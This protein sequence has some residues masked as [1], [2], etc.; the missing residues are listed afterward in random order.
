[1]ASSA[2]ASA[3]VK[4]SI[5]TI[6]GFPADGIVKMVMS[7]KPDRVVV[8]SLGKTGIE[9]RVA[10]PKRWLRKPHAGACHKGRDRGLS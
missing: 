7:E 5:H 9:H 3:G 8:G 1:M 6:R 2:R 10:I 4:I